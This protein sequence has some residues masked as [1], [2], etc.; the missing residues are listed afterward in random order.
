[1][2]Y[3]NENHSKIIVYIVYST[4][5]FSINLQGFL[6]LEIAIVQNNTHIG[7]AERAFSVIS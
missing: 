4:M 6:L 2:K 1:M 7:P 3:T 5:E